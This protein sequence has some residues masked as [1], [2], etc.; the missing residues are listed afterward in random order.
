MRLFTLRRAIP[1]CVLLAG[2]LSC[3][4]GV[5]LAAQTTT[6]TNFQ[7]LVSNAN[8]ARENGNVDAAIRSYREALKLRPEWTEGWWDLGMVQYESNRYRDAAASLR[9]LTALAPDAPPGWSLLGLAEFETGDY[10]AAQAAFQRA[11]Q[12]GGAKDP[13]IA[14]VTAYH[15]ALLLVR[16]GQFDRAAALLRSTFGASI[17][18]QAKTVLGL[19]LLRVPLL[20]TEIDPSKDALVQAAGE[21]AADPTP[22]ALAALVAQYPKTP[23]LHYA[24]AQALAASGQLDAAMKQ[25]QMEAAISP[26]SPLPWTA[27]SRLSLKLHEVRQSRAQARQAARLA[28]ATPRDPRMIALYAAHTAAAAPQNSAAWTV[29]MRSYSAGNYPAAITALESWVAQH[30]KDGTA[31]AVMGLAEYALRDYGNARIHLQRGVNL[32]V[33]GSAGE[34]QL[35][36]D[37]L[38]LLLICE[39]KFD[40]ATDLLK[41]QANQPPLAQQTQFALGLALLRV[42]KLPHQLTPKQRSLAQAAGAI[43]PLL[44]ASHYPEAFARF[45]ALIAAN[46]SAPWLHYAYGNAL[47]ALSHYDEAIAQ[48]KIETGVSPHSALPWIRIA[49]I[50]LRRHQTAPALAAA[51]TAAR[52]AP[53]SAQAHYELGRA[54]LESGDT[55]KSITE[56]ERANAL[57]PNAPQ[58]H[59]T[60]ARAYARAGQSKKAAAE[61]AA[62]LQLQ[63]QEQQNTQGQSILHTHTQ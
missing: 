44:Y 53:N 61:R 22:Q 57:Q 28:R 37:R 42:T 13:D 60:L 5:V 30:P 7:T 15:Y 23:W 16:S 25:Q 52:L 43:V 35:A 11:Q 19:A 1:A 59:F 9:K 45:Q 58:I 10:T 47:D 62:F 21:A 48:M 26:G 20:P 18:A 49:A 38:G 17:P 3:G 32:G 8:A 63:S 55:A 14:R 46:P 33:K 34:V 51:Q 54:W 2:V 6:G 29:A 40:L 36:R 56:L 12:L 41:A 27:M 31:W 4:C 39:G 24:Y 50:H